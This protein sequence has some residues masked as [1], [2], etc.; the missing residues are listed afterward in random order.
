MGKENDGHALFCINPECKVAE[1]G[2]CIEGIDP[3]DECPHYASEKSYEVDE[4]VGIVED[5]DLEVDRTTLPPSRALLSNEASNVLKKE[6]SKVICILGPSDSGKTCLIA[7]VYDMFQIGDKIGIDFRGSQSLLAFEKICHDSRAESK[8][9]TPHSPRTPYG[10]VNFYHLNL[11]MLENHNKN[12]SLL[13]ADRAGEEYKSASDDISLVDDFLE[14]HRADTINVLID[15][16]RLIDNRARHN[17]KNDITMMLQ[18]LKDQ[19][20]IRSK[21]QLAIVLT[22]YDAVQQSEYQSRA[23][24]DLNNIVDNITSRL[25]GYIFSIEVFKVAASPKGGDLPRGAGVL[26]LLKYWLNSE[27]QKPK[28]GTGKLSGK[29][30]FER[31]KMTSELE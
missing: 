9:N 22:K 20:G 16:E 30:F 29:R 11:C 19:S 27:I 31:L 15:G 5:N 18:A 6:D 26:N 3:C 25:N 4:S 24:S 23:L 10:P 2:R 8:R 12:L 28:I 21:P 7:S 1:T 13:I 14:V 17:L